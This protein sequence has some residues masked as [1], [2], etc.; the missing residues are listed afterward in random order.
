MIQ[1]RLGH[2]VSFYM[3]IM[4]SGCRNLALSHNQPVDTQRTAV[5]VFHG[6]R[7]RPNVYTPHLTLFCHM[8]AAGDYVIH[9]N[10]V[11]VAFVSS[12]ASRAHTYRFVTK[13]RLLYSL[14][15]N[16]DLL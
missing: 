13:Y 16:L 14:L 8:F 6:S 15:L 2:G 10:V 5:L 4:A 9:A 3:L 12:V 7:L 1:D 11:S